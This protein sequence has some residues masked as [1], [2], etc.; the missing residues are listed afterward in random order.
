[1][2]SDIKKDIEEYFNDNW[3]L[4]PIQW[5]GVKFDTVDSWISL[6]LIPIER[7][8]NTCTRKYENLQLQVLCYDIS[9]TKV[10]ELAD[11]VYS[12]VDCIDLTTCYLSVGGSDGLGVIPL[13]NQVSF[14]N[15]IFEVN[16]NY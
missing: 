7:S 10:F 1:M 12:F 14:L 11:E 2:I 3:A 15:T 5:E 4:T 16:S 6:K 13:E 9:N 8:S